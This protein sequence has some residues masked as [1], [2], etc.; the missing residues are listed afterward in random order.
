MLNVL[1]IHV[2]LYVNLLYFLTIPLSPIPQLTQPIEIIWKIQTI[3][4]ELTY[5]LHFHS[6]YFR[7]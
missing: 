6:T 2:I 3:T 4:Y 5:I 7:L 1:D